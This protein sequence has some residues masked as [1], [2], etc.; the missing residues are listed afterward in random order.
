[1]GCGTELVMELSPPEPATSADLC[2]GR[3]G[4]PLGALDPIAD[5]LLW[6]GIVLA[7][8]LGSV[9]RLAL[10][11]LGPFQRAAG[12]QRERVHLRPCG[13]HLELGVR[14]LMDHVLAPWVIRV[15][16]TH[17][18]ITSHPEV[19][20]IRSSAS[21]PGRMRELVDSIEAGTWLHFAI[22]V[23][24]AERKSCQTR[25]AGPIWAWASCG[26]LAARISSE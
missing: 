5:D 8:H 6:D 4:H 14:A 7:L 21:A 11:P 17:H 16:A 10:E 3:I 19:R 25:N 9:K 2:M 26:R 20:S 24:D 18:A 15:L 12:R 1:M 13:A 22:V 23:S